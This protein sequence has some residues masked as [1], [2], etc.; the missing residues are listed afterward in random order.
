MKI[1]ITDFNSN[2]SYYISLS[3]KEPIELLKRG[4]V[5]AVIISK[6]LYEKSKN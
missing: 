2:I 3:Q 6:K 4:V 1:S 5:V